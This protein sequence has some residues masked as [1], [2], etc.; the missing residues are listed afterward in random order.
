M[1]LSPPEH[2]LQA[3]PPP[4]QMLGLVNGF[5]IACALH[6]ATELGLADLLQS[7][8]T[9]TDLALETQTH[10]DS[11]YRLMR[12]LANIGV[13]QEVT[14]RCF[15][16]TPL[17]ATLSS[18]RPGSQRD[19]VLMLLAPWQRRSWEHLTD[20]VR[21]GKAA[22]PEVYN[23]DLWSYFSEVN[24]EAGRQ[25]DQALTGAYNASNQAIVQSYDFSAIQTVAD[26]GGGQGAL[27]TAILQH[28]PHLHGLLFDRPAVVAETRHR[29]DQTVQ[30]RIQLC[31]GD[32]FEGVP[33]GIDLYLLRQ[34]LHDWGDE[35]CLR[36]LERCRQAM[37][38][39]GRLLII[40]RILA[41]ESPPTDYFLD[42]QHLVLLGQGRERSLEDFVQL[43]TRA[44][45]HLLQV[46]PTSS[47]FSLLEVGAAS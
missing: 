29:L 27:L 38:A 15:A 20:S 39:N 37:P 5:R 2:V 17:S 19:M 44:Q 43:F 6:T 3:P 14:P 7:P 11:L 4:L 31:E 16:Q 40:E 36:V 30:E 21:T 32:F 24:P 8:R 28:Y 10:E 46:I 13:F 23:T 47:P 25:F 9:V 45:L 35:A 26:I 12:A 34:V 41:P 33:A 1:T 42:V 18:Q 22:F